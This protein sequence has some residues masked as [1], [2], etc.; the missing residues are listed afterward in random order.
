MAEDTAANK[1]T[2]EQAQ[3][4][5]AAVPLIEFAGWCVTGKG[6]DPMVAEVLAFFEKVRAAQEHSGARSTGSD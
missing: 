5:R 1:P 4:Q 2:A 3:L 6:H